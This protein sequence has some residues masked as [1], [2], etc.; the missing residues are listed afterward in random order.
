MIVLVWFASRSFNHPTIGIDDANIFFTY[1][2]NLVA[3][4]GLVYNAGGEKV[5]GFT[6][7]LWVFISAGLFKMRFNEIGVLTT[8]IIFLVVAQLAILRVIRHGGKGKGTSLP[9]QQ[10]PLWR[11]RFLS[12][13]VPPPVK[14]QPPCCFP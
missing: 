9:E 14:F 7:L 5:E 13:P 10:S 4:H 3:G 12:L 1:A 11:Q 6:S 2:E 8:S